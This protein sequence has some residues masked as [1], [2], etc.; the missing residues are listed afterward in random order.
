METSSTPSVTSVV[1]ANA[2]V[3]ATN[4]SKSSPFR[5]DSETPFLDSLSAMIPEGTVALFRCLVFDVI[6]TSF[7][8]LLA[9]RDSEDPSSHD[10]QAL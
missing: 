10:P 3:L 5:M 4:S 6:H 7:T 2:L 9:M 1:E 8:C